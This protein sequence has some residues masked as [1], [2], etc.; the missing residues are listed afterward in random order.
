MKQTEDREDKWLVACFDVDGLH[1]GWL[2][3]GSTLSYWSSKALRFSSKQAADNRIVRL[4]LTW[5][6][7]YIWCAEKAPKHDIDARTGLR[8]GTVYVASDVGVVASVDTGAAVQLDT[9]K[10]QPLKSVTA[11]N[12]PTGQQRQDKGDSMPVVKKTTKTLKTTTK[13]KKPAVAVPVEVKAVPKMKMRTTAAAKAKSA[14][15]AASNDASGRLSCICGCG[16]LST[17]FLKRGHFK[18]IIGYIRDIKAGTIKPEKAFGSK[19]LAAAWGPWT[20]TKAGGFTTK[21]NDYAKV[22]ANLEA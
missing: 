20:A 22:R 4:E 13:T 11:S 16:E 10:T 7:S 19:Q 9:I 5:P 18:R 12:R 8:L 1:Q 2:T 3:N 21:T 14:K 17:N 15:A 6:M